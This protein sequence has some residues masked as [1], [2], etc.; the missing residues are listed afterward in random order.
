M[1]DHVHHPFVP[2][3]GTHSRHGAHGEKCSQGESAEGPVKCTGEVPILLELPGLR[4]MQLIWDRS[5]LSVGTSPT[6]KK[7]ISP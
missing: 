1:S 7:V 3:D 2:S 6:D 5:F 4:P